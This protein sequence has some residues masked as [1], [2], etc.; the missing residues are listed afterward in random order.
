M[1]EF[2]F[3]KPRYSD[4]AKITGAHEF[5][6]DLQRLARMMMTKSVRGKLGSLAKQ[7]IYSNMRR[8]ILS[9]GNNQKYSKSY[10][11]MRRKA[12]L[13]AGKVKMIAKKGKTHAFTAIFKPSLS[14][15]SGDLKEQSAL[16]RPRKLIATD[17]IT[18]RK[19]KLTLYEIFQI[20]AEKGYNPVL[21]NLPDENQLFSRYLVY[22]NKR[23]YKIFGYDIF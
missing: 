17:S 14:F 8:S 5:R 4:F 12:G 10:A 20:Q 22:L 11:Q 23:A 1:N 19:K 2:R 18:G 21:F 13:R 3:L 16:V 6:N 15:R 9:G 7:F